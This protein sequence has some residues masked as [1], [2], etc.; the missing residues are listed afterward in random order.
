LSSIIAAFAQWTRAKS[1]D[2]FGVFG[3]WIVTGLDPLAP[4]VRTVVAGKERR[5]YPVA[6]MFFPPLDI[7]SR[8]SHDM[9]LEPGDIIAC[10]TSIGA[11]AMQDG[12]SVEIAIDGIGY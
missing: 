1:F 4:R 8:I 7:V 3:P 9:T 12:D 5:N 2:T 11:G 10:G 6:D